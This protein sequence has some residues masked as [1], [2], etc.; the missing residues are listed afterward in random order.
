MTKEEIFQKCEQFLS[1]SKEKQK[2]ILSSFS[3]TQ[4]E[5]FFSYLEKY[6]NSMNNFEIDFSENNKQTVKNKS[7]FNL[8]RSILISVA[9]LIIVFSLLDH[10]EY[11]SLTDEISNLFTHK[12]SQA[13]D[14]YPH[15]P[16]DYDPPNNIDKVTEYIQ[17]GDVTEGTQP[18][19]QLSYEDSIK[20]LGYVY[21]YNIKLNVGDTSDFIEI[22]RN[23][24][25]WYVLPVGKDIQVLKYGDDIGVYIS[26]NSKETLFA[27]YIRGPYPLYF[28]FIGVENNTSI[29]IYKK[30]L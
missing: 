29:N 23:I 22:G 27:K 12:N 10:L 30:N 5:V 8:I 18:V 24:S 1:F 16:G 2:E 7:K 6:Q 28:R 4:Q 14:D 13:Y 11:F 25:L 3:N 26:K 19:Q 15:D 9:F 21:Q 20:S 17:P